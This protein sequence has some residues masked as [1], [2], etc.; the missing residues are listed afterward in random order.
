MQPHANKHTLKTHVATQHYGLPFIA[1]VCLNFILWVKV[2]HWFF[3]LPGAN[4]IN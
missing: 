2:G 4:P 3:P 1:A